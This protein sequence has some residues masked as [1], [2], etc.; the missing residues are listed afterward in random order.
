MNAVSINNIQCYIVIYLQ[1]GC[2]LSHRIS[3]G[4]L[5]YYNK[6]ASVAPWIARAQWIALGAH[7][8]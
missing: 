2:G 5:V 3:N 1:C 6:G 7:D 4:I 8:Q